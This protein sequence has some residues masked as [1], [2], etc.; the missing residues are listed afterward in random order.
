MWADTNQ[1]RIGTPT[2]AEVSGMSGPTYKGEYR[3]T[4]SA[5]KANTV[6]LSIPQR[7]RDT[8]EDA[9]CAVNPVAEFI[10]TGADAA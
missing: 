6:Y 2:A 4:L 7:N 9:A 5:H 3:C 8:H 10:S 1:M